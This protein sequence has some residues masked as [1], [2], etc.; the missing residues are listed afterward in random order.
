MKKYRKTI[1]AFITS[2]C[3]SFILIY[4]GLLSP[5]NLRGMEIGRNLMSIPEVSNYFSGHDIREVKYL[6][7]STYKVVTDKSNFI[8]I[9]DYSDRVF[10]RYKIFKYDTE[11][12]YF[13]NPM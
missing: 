7:S 6:G 10:W 3:V 12:E 11:L 5:Y 8:V 9:T 1:I 4:I 2:I 13:S